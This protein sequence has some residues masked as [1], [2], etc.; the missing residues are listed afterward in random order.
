MPVLFAESEDRIL[1][2]PVLFAELEDPIILLTYDRNWVRIINDI[3]QKGEKDAK[4]IQMQK[5]RT[6][7]GI[8]EFLSR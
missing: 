7:S 6:V 1:F 2:M 3:C 8:P 4:T 5:D